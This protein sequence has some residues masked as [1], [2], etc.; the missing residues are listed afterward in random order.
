LVFWRHHQPLSAHVGVRGDT[1]MLVMTW[2]SA[3]TGKVAASIRRYP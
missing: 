3:T 2:N 1:I